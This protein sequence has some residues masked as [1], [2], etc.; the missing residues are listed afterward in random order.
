MRLT[1]T[2]A[3]QSAGFTLIEV[4]IVVAI[5]AILG[6]VALPSYSDYVTRGR[7]PEATSQLA[8]KRV[9]MEQ[10]FQD[11]GTYAG[12]PPCTAETLKSFAFSCSVVGTATAFTLQAVGSG[13]MT[14][15][16]FTIDQS[17]AQATVISTGA[18]SG[19]ASNAACWTSK[20]GGVC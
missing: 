5:V 4:M 1:K 8:A 11:N 16:T 6:S 12:A 9:Q 14:G 3:A 2:S 19:W 7:I 18:P 10:F 20:K 17:N 13:S 15:F